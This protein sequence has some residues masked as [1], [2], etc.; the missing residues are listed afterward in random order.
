MVSTFS[1]TSTAL[2]LSSCPSFWLP[3][4]I[5]TSRFASLSSKR[6]MPALTAFSK[7][8]A[9]VTGI[10]SIPGNILVSD[11]NCSIL[12]S[13]PNATTAALFPFGSPSSA[14]RTILTASSLL[15]EKLSE[16]STRN[17]VPVFLELTLTDISDIAPI[18]KQS[19]KILIPIINPLRTLLPIL[20]PCDIRS[21]ITIVTG[22]NN[23]IIGYCTVIFINQPPC[24]ISTDVSCI[25][26]T[27]L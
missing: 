17:T 15:A 11:I 2:I 20:N 3:S 24:Q 14:S 8:V 19:S 10:V 13:E 4:V 18:I 6:A 23:N 9:V 21:I 25:L 22:I 16:T 12:A 1:A 5:S 27:L 7:L 26:S